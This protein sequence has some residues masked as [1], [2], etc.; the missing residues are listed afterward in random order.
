M[1]VSWFP[2]IQRLCYLGGVAFYGV[3]WLAA[4]CFT[5]VR[6]VVYDVFRFRQSLLLYLRVLQGLKYSLISNLTSV[7]EDRYM[8]AEIQPDKQSLHVYLKIQQGLKYSVI[9]NLSSVLEDTR[10]EVVPDKQ[11]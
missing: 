10:P 2:P 1:F 7:L 11:S 5:V 3:S 8:W 4:S 9:S 6:F